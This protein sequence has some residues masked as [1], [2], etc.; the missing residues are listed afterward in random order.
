MK[1]VSQKLMG[2]KPYNRGG[3]VKGLNKKK[4][5]TDGGDDDGK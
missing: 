5:Q 4:Y 3:M 1:A 2:R